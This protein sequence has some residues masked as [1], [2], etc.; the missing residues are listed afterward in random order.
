M[1]KQ[2]TMQHAVNQH[3]VVTVSLQFYNVEEVYL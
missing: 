2:D 1:E 3:H